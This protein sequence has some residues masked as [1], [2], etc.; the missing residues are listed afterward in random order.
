MDILAI[1]MQLIGYF[2]N[3]IDQFGIMGIILEAVFILVVF[4]IIQATFE[5]GDKFLKM[6]MIVAVIV[7]ILSFLYYMGSG[8]TFQAMYAEFWDSLLKMLKLN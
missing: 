2:T 4:V 1:I 5:A 6:G 8:D 3:F 7:F